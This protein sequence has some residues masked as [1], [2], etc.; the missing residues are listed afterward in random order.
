M[1][2]WRLVLRLIVRRSGSARPAPRP[3]LPDRDGPATARPLPEAAPCGR[4]Q[5]V[6]CGR[7]YVIDGDTID[8]A[9]VR[10]RLFGI[11]APELDHPY[12]NTAKW[13]LVRLCKGVTIRAELDGALS[14]QRSVALCYL[15]DGRDLSAEMVKAGMAIDWTRYSGGRYRHLEVPGIRRRLWR[16]DARQKGRM[17]PR[18]PD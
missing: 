12:G 2:L 14:H 17:P 16:C 11:D 10:I 9:G 8:I 3:A 4:Q 5:R 1:G 13:T 18:L 7:A 6:V 15:P